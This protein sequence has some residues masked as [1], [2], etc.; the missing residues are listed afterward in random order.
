L[1]AS[2]PGTYNITVKTS[3]IKGGSANDTAYNI[4]VALYPIIYTDKPSYI[5]CG[6]VYYKVTVT[7]LS[8]APIDANLSIRFLNS[9]G[10]LQNESNATTGNGGTGIYKGFYNLLSSA[11]LGK[12]ILQAVTESGSVG[13]TNFYVGSGGADLWKIT[14]WLEPDSV[15]YEPDTNVTVRFRVEDMRGLGVGGLNNPIYMYFSIDNG[16]NLASQVSDLGDGNYAYSF[17]VIGSGPHFIFVRAN[18]SMATSAYA[19]ISY[20]VR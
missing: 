16:P 8:D 14:M 11:S 17:F 15:K 18:N 5:N 1:N 7:D 3:C 9:T 20:A 12:W 10:A 6:R 13:Q 4:T 19:S 2:T